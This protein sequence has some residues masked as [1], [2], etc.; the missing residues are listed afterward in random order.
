LNE[1]KLSKR[2]AKVAEFV[3]SHA[4]M[5]DIGTDHAYLPVSL[6]LEDKISFAVAGDVVEGPYLSA[7]HQVEKNG[8]QEKIS[9]RLGSGLDVIE[10]ETDKITDITIA[11]MG[12]AL[13]SEIL[14]AGFKKGQLT[15]S[16]TLI[17]EPNVGEEIVRNWLVH[18]KYQI[19]AE[20]ILEENDK[21]YE[22]IQARPVNEKIELT[23]NERK[24]GPFLAQEKSP[25]FI[26]KWQGERDNLKRVLENL[27]LAKTKPVEKIKEITNEIKRIEEVIS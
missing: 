26:K 24:F 15:H 13:I 11:G 4:R 19:I 14:E 16:E 21:I 6:M 25:V 1:E 3:S 23:E 7:K 27:N 9:V 12:G 20:A 5:A 2:L 17:L 10:P 8:L 22:I 18:N